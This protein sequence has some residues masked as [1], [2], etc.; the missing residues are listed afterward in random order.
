MQNQAM[1]LAAGAIAGNL[2]TTRGSGNNGTKSH[3]KQSDRVRAGKSLHCD[4]DRYQEGKVSRNPLF[5]RELLTDRATPDRRYH[6]NRGPPRSFGPAP[7]TQMEIPNIPDR[8]NIRH[9][10]SRSVVLR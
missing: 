3:G 8:L 10:E 6:R 9:W 1:K 5:E 7:G 4:N 2:L